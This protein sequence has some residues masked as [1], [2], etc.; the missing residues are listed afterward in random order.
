ME[1]IQ[2]QDPK[3]PVSPVDPPAPTFPDVTNLELKIESRMETLPHDS[4]AMYYQH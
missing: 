4:S 3:G 2:G 1:T